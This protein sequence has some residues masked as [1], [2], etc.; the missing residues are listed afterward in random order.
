MSSSSYY[1]SSSYSWSYPSSS[2]YN[3][4]SSWSYSS[5]S[6]SSSS[7]ATPNSIEIKIGGAEVT[8]G[9]GTGV[10][11]KVFEVNKKVSVTLTRKG[12]CW[13]S[14]SE[15]EFSFSGAQLY[16]GDANGNTEGTPVVSGKRY[17]FD[18]IP[19]LYMITT[20]PSDQWNTVRVQATAYPNHGS[21]SS[22]WHAGHSNSS[23]SSNDQAT[24][25][26]ITVDA[27]EKP[28]GS[29]GSTGST[30]SGWGSP[31]NG[32]RPV[33]GKQRP[34]FHLW[35][36]NENAIRANVSPGSMNDLITDSSFNGIAATAPADMSPALN[37]KE[38]KWKI[39][40]SP[41]NQYLVTATVTVGTSGTVLT[42]TTT[43]TD[44]VINKIESV[45]WLPQGTPNTRNP[46]TTPVYLAKLEAHGGAYRAFPEKKEPFLKNPTTGAIT[47]SPAYNVV[48]ARITLVIKIPDYM[49]GKIGVYTAWFDPK[50]PKGSKKTHKPDGTLIT[51]PATPI[52]ANTIRDNNGMIDMNGS[53]VTFNANEKSK[54]KSFTI[55]S[56]YAGDDYIV[57]VHPNLGT[58]NLYRLKASDGKTLERPNGNG[59]ADVDGELQTKILTVWRTLWVELDR[60]K[61]PSL[62][63]TPGTASDGFTFDTKYAGSVTKDDGSGKQIPIQQLWDTQLRVD[64]ATGH[65]P[66]DFDLAV[67]PTFPDIILLFPALHAAC[68]DAKALTQQQSQNWSIA[69]NPTVSFVRWLPAWSNPAFTGV[70]N[71]RDLNV[72]NDAAFWNV[73]GLG[74]FNPDLAKAGDTSSSTW[75]TGGGA[76]VGIG[77]FIIF[78]EA[79]RDQFYSRKKIGQ[80]FRPIS[81]LLQG[82]VIHEVL[83]LFGFEDRPN[84]NLNNPTNDDIENGLVMSGK[85]FVEGTSN[86]WKTFSPAQIRKIQAKANPQ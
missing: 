24:A 7:S 41:T 48:E 67:Q 14:N 28:W 66:D 47:P 13:N 19:S 37:N 9:G 53:T 36:I 74:A 75:A 73:C 59:W 61:A 30:N 50:N 60:M 25:Y 69:W 63:T 33:D 22:S 16:F 2:P 76:A 35:D 55:T 26:R 45:V 79:K 65:E 32:S 6:S 68:I 21:S 11:Y 29:G 57:A 27:R 71:Q 72:R 17:S 12:N 62:P 42:G 86:E 34:W 44:I 20:S 1:S 38:P 82:V 81:E 23:C 39:I 4:S 54:D 70:A 58:V 78:C 10:K 3:S 51:T 83:H 31:T 56:A 52:S 46:N 85:Y 49:G 18:P 40:T 84:Y 64:P 77:L 15:I 43:P 8:P 5:S 80:N